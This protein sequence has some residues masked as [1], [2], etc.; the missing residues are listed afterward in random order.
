MANN[1]TL[2]GNLWTRDEIDLANAVIVKGSALSEE[3][4]HL[5]ARPV[6]AIEGAAGDRG[7]GGYG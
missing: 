3:R 2:W 1:A 4:G 5:R 6:A 7:R